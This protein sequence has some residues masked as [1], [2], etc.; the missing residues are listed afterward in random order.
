MNIKTSVLKTHGL[1]SELASLTELLGE[2]SEPATKPAQLI[3]L[4]PDQT[5]QTKGLSI[6]SSVS[7]SFFQSG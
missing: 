1:D 7:F 2:G 5:N 6:S 4:V 3:N